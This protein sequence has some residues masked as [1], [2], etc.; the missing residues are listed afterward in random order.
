MKVIILKTGEVKEVAEG[1][2]R[3]YL[4]PNKLATPA[5]AEKIKKAEDK[6]QKI[7]AEQNKQKEQEQETI[8]K[9]KDI[10]VKIQVKTS[11]EG[12]M[13]AALKVE[14]IGQALKEQ[15]QI[16]LPYEW[17]NIKEPIKEAGEYEVEI[18]TRT[19]LK[20][21]LKIQLNKAK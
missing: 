3:N 17:I 15:Y 14:E 9:L 5:T 2:A 19:D 18:T 16:E 20:A 11:E 1:Y 12:K 8:N 10:V 4:L 13:F 6:K 7:Q 21:K